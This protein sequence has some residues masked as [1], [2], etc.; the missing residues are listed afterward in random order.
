MSTTTELKNL[1]ETLYRQYHSLVLQLCLGYMKGDLELAKD[2]TQEVFINIWNALAG[3]KRES[4]P[5]TWIY[6]I[7]VNTC[8]LHIR[9]NKNRQT[10]SLEDAPHV[11]GIEL[12]ENNYNQHMAL[13]KAI[14]EL[15]QLERVIIMLVLEELEYE[16]ISKITGINPINLRVKIHRIKKKMKQLLK[17]TLNNG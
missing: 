1:F 7:T 16:E 9:S 12:K 14:G 13:Y 2:I 8:L 10:T 15:P 3:F 4:S 17:L 5:K 11:T 6:R